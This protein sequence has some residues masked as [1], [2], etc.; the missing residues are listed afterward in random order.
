ML[1]CGGYRKGREVRSKTDSALLLC[2]EGGPE[3][4]TRPLSSYLG[5]EE[6]VMVKPHP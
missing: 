3:R 6:C 4:V 1:R 5:R 2:R